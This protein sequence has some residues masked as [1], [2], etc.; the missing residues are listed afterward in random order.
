MAVRRG[1]VNPD[2]EIIE[3]Q[4]CYRGFFRLEKYRLRHRLYNGEMSGTI[5][6]ELLER[7]NA[8]ALLPYDPIRDEVV[9]LEQFRIGALQDTGGPWLPEIVAG[10]IGPGETPEQVVRREAM[11]EAGCVVHELEPICEYLVSPGSSSE[12]MSLF[13]G[14]VDSSG[15]GGVHGL[16]EENEDILA[17]VVPFEQF[18]DDCLNG[19][20]NTAIPLIA[21]Y[22]LSM[23]RERLR[24]CWGRD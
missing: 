13:C 5:S 23:H 19:K 11:E 14:R 2:V 24:E 21:G 3:K 6:R 4:E 15:V 9:L 7:G 16:D 22:W 20:L 18:W 12:R 8:A 10:M 1:P 17:R